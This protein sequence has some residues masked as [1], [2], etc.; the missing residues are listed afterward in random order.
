MCI[1]CVFV[2]YIFY[3][4]THKLI[5]LYVCMYAFCTDPIQSH[6]QP[7]TCAPSLADITS[8]S[9]KGAETQ[10]HRQKAN[11][12]QHKR[13]TNR[14]KYRQSRLK[15]IVSRSVH[16][17]KHFFLW[18]S[19][20]PKRRVCRL[21][22]KAPTNRQQHSCWSRLKSQSHGM[23]FAESLRCTE[24]LCTEDTDSMALL[25]T[26][27]HVGYV[28]CGV[29]AWSDGF[30]WDMSQSCCDFDVKLLAKNIIK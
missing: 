9:T 26:T 11:G 1:M 3:I 14:L 6:T 16:K 5:C 27:V 17:H 23:S 25:N 12:F 20:T 4:Y 28:N 18:C 2:F 22:A 13:A 21:S 29:T 10:R 8:H 15:I 7:P 24:C 19:P 30:E